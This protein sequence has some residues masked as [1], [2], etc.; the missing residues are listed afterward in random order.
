[1]LR[2]WPHDRLPVPPYIANHDGR[3]QYDWVPVNLAGQAQ[4]G[5]R[6]SPYRSLA[7]EH[8]G[9]LI[10]TRGW[11]WSMKQPAVNGFHVIHYGPRQQGAHAPR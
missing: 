6:V 1:M 10:F 5:G 11:E 8:F 9:L 7:A 3:E 4:Q 2:E